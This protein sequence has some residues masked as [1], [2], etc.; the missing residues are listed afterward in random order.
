M[1]RP[2]QVLHMLPDLQVGGGQAVLLNHIRNLSPARFEHHVCSVQPLLDMEQA[3]RDAGARVHCL[4]LRRRRDVPRALVRLLRLVRTLRIDLIH[5]NNTRLD[6]R[7]GE[8]AGTLRRRPVVNTLHAGTGSEP[9]AWG[10]MFKRGYERLMSRSIRHVIAVSE[11]VRQL[12]LPVL[13][14]GGLGDQVTLIRPGIDMTRFAHALPPTRVAELRS[15]LAVPGTGPVLITV[16]RLQHGKGL[17]HLP[18]IMNA[19]R[20]HWPTATLLL[21]GDG[22]LRSQIEARFREHGLHDAVRFAG[23]RHDVPELLKLSDLFVFPSLAEGFGLAPLEAMAAG[24][25][26]AA[27]AL[28]AYR[29][30]AEDTVTGVFAPVGDRE[31]LAGRVVDLLRQP[32]VMAA[33]G[34]RGREV[35]TTHF[36]QA[37]S[38]AALDRVYSDLLGDREDAAPAPIAA[39]LS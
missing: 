30:F 1:S 33:M 14:A 22:P 31:A 4:E 15:E 20:Q 39:P 6:R 28:P 5:T 27:Y 29:E 12:Y 17:D 38:T 10:A 25:P 24:R 11:S 8:C 7:F 18:Q 21:V 2:Y 23:T 16:S 13:R 3:F 9:Q 35:V 37:K 36:L 26:V 34:R 32:Q 19:V